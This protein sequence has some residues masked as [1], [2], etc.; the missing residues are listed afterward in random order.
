MWYS[1]V[2]FLVRG[3]SPQARGAPLVQLRVGEPVGT[4]PAG[5]GST[6]GYCSSTAAGRDHPRRR[7]EHPGWDRPSRPRQGP[8]PQARGAQPQALPRQLRHGTIPAGAGS[9]PARAAAR[10][11]P[12]DHPRR[13]GEHLVAT[14]VSVPNRGPSPQARGA[15]PA[16]HGAPAGGGTIPAGAGSTERFEVGHEIT[17]DHPRR[18]GEHTL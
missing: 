2:L 5:A 18:R 3:P 7:G 12:R 4:I 13:R 11:S 17:E 15:H 1:R 6:L 9:T 8:S 14:D 10:R 16:H